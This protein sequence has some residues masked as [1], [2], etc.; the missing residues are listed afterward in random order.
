MHIKKNKY[1]IMKRDKPLYY[2]KTTG[3]TGEAKLIPMYIKQDNASFFFK[4]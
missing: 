4:K 3:T 1:I 2:V